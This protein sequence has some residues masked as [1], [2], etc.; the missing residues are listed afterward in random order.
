MSGWDIGPITSVNL[1]LDHASLPDGDIIYKQADISPDDA[2][3]RFRQFLRTF[4]AANGFS[5]PYRERLIEQYRQ[6]QF[7][8]SVDLYHLH[9]A[10]KLLHDLLIRR[11]SEFLPLLEAAATEVA[12]V[13]VGEDDSNPGVVSEWN[14]DFHYRKQRMQVQLV[15][16]PT[17]TAIRQLTS[18]HV[19][20]LVCL[21]GIIVSAGRPRVKPLTL[22]IICRNCKVTKFIQAVAG[23]NGVKLPRKCDSRPATGSDGPQCP[24]DPYIILSDSTTYIDQQRLKLQELTGTVPTGEMPRVMSLACD[25][26]LCG[27]VKPGSRVKVT[28]MYTT[29]E[30]NAAGASGG[31]GQQGVEATDRGIRIPY[32]R[33]MGIEEED[34]ASDQWGDL[35]SHDGGGL[36]GGG[37]DDDDA[38]MVELSKRPNLY[39]QIAASMC[40]AIFDNDDTANIKQALAIQLF[41]GARK[42]LPDGMRLRGD[43][44]M[45]LLGDPSVAKSQFLKFVSAV[46]PIGV[47]TSGKGSSAA[48]LTAS[49]IRDPGTGEF[50]L[51]GGALVLADGGLV[52]IDEFD[53]MREQD[54]VAIHEAME[55]QTI[56]IAKAGITTILNARTSVLAAA[57]PIFG[58]YDDM[59]SA[60]D[61]IDFQTSIL[62]RFDLIFIVRDMQDTARDKQLAKHVLNVHRQGNA[63]IRQLEREGVEHIPIELLRRYIAYARRHCQPRLD[64][65][66]ATL[67]K[68]HYV[69]FR[70][71]V[72]K[73]ARQA[74]GGGGG[75]VIPITVR[76]LEAIVRISEAYA[77]MELSEH[78][79]K[80]HVEEAI[81]LFQVS[82]YRAAMHGGSDSGRGGGPSVGLIGGSEFD[83]QVLSAEREVRLRVSSGSTVGKEQLMA[84]VE[85]RGLT[86]VAV[87]RALT[88]MKQRGEVDY[89]R[90]G[91]VVKRL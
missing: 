64:E 73:E 16:A 6:G 83:R 82:T 72:A 37:G 55:Q 75:G 63:A 10:D 32:I 31:G 1:N 26:Y 53:K 15:H 25:R 14:D 5:Y 54:R 58:R 59:R 45:L 33:V 4:K 57:N 27:S 88:N 29:Y 35:A 30:S 44:N 81:R 21:H 60:S 24:L 65:D 71:S 28:G 38:E 91:R 87:E 61:N 13:G 70:H 79:T 40:P 18:Q 67:L 85:G 23:F 52:A 8:V 7:H 34:D 41:G 56:S 78:A 68:N 86:R 17:V 66:A 39:A 46:A 80:K 3:R 77:R 19:S 36:L 84:W 62:S 51:E 2:H 49:V 42:Q 48:G 9:V 69:Q 50:H 74:G 11:P 20:H 76:Q 22:H 47:Y 43:I 90:M 12:R 89:F